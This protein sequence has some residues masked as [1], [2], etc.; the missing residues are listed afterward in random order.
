MK[1]LKKQQCYGDELG[2]GAVIDPVWHR[3]VDD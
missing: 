3:F 1:W 2:D